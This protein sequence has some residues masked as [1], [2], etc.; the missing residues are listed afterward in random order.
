MRRAVIGAF[1]VVP[2][3][4][5][6]LV[7]QVAPAYFDPSHS[8]ADEPLRELVELL[9]P[10]DPEVIAARIGVLVQACDA[11][12][13]LVENGLRP[14]PRTTKRLAPDGTLLTLDLTG[15]PFGAP[16]RECPGQVLAIAVATAIAEELA[17]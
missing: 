4:A 15:N 9:G 14:P 5:L 13:A 8:A 16:P 17:S 11:T 2:D 10:G 1:G 7:L 12:A 6:D 3:K